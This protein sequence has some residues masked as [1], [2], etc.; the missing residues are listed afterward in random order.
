MKDDVNSTV[1]L[2]AN[3]KLC[4]L[5]FDDFPGAQVCASIIA[6]LR[7]RHLMNGR[8]DELFLRMRREG[9][10][11]GCRQKGQA[12]VWTRDTIDGNR[13]AQSEQIQLQ[14]LRQMR[15][16]VDRSMQI[17]SL[18]QQWFLR[19]GILSKQYTP[20][21]AVIGFSSHL[22]DKFNSVWHD[23]PSERAT[24]RKMTREKNVTAISC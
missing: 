22:E 9:L 4:D 2:I 17:S 21:C 18:L 1:V 5:R 14:F 12:I 6:Q 24:I 3:N 16:I 8:V 7:S 15:D 10:S 20:R 11:V 13:K 23:F 19:C